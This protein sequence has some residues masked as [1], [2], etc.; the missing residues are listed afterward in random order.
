MR[1]VKGWQHSVQ[2]WSWEM[3]LGT[4][5]APSRPASA[6]EHAAFPAP[7]SS[8]AFLGPCCMDASCPAAALR[9]EGCFWAV[10]PAGVTLSW[11]W[12]RQS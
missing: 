3:L 1:Q 5:M 4:T 6:G 10:G 8:P 11:F 9:P 12:L 2:P 7:A